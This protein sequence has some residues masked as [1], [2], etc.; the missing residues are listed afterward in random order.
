MDTNNSIS[1]DRPLISIITVVFNG[2]AFLEKALNSVFGQDFK[3]IEYIVIDGGSTDESIEIIEKYS[4][5][6]KYWVS[7]PDEGIYH[8]MNKGL[9]V[10]KGQW[11]YFLGSDDWMYNCLAEVAKYLKDENVIYYGDVY[12]TKLQRKYDGKFST[13]KL[14]Y[15]NICQQSIFYPIKLWSKHSFNLKYRIFADYEFNIRCYT[16]SVNKFEH[17]PITISC[18]NDYDGLSCRGQD[19]EFEKDRLNIV[20]DN[21]SVLIFR[22]VWLRTKIIEILTWM[23]VDQIILKLNR[24]IF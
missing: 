15:R 4:S 1:T 20:K 3:N 23:K 5:R 22:L 18:Y 24:K 12:R 21:F 9:K 2:A 8:A 11:I 6:L 19:V 16:D 14:A 17:I 13:Y 10:A 7:E